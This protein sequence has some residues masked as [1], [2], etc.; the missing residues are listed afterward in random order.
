MHSFV[1]SYVGERVR[2]RIL[3][4]S[5]WSLLLLFSWCHLSA[6]TFLALYLCTKCLQA[7]IL[8]S[9]MEIVAYGNIHMTLDE[10]FLRA[11]REHASARIL[12]G[13]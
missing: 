9:G 1:C 4:H 13:I 10:R 5:K 11:I 3:E 2:I 12:S 8:W 7:S 6:V